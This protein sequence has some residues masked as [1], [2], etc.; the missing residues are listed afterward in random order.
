MM[1]PESSPDPKP[2]SRNRVGSRHL[3]RDRG[4]SLVEF[5]LS[6]SILMTLILGVFSMSIALYSYDFISE[7]AREGTRFAIVRGSSCS[8]YGNFASDCPVT[9]SSQVQTYVRGLAYPGIKSS[10]L[11]VTAT[12]PDTGATCTPSSS[13]CNNPGNRVKVVVSYQFPMNV[14][15][16][17]KTTLTMS[18]TSE[19]VISD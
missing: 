7:A 14:P 1:H 11:T 16:V 17:S 10:N 19:M 12:W 15:G 13:P 6:V 9:T 3:R 4:S 8:K 5:G 18:S 2:Y